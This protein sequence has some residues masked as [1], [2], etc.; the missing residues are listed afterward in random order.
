MTA[1]FLCGMFAAWAIAQALVGL[2]FVLAYARGR[3]ESEY[4]LFGLICFAL[5]LATGGIARS[6]VA[7]SP[8]AWL[9]SGI[10]TH[11]GAITATALN[12]HFVLSYATKSK[13]TRPIALVAYALAAGYVGVYLTGHWWKEG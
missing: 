3:R 13:L 2:F 1:A 11:A 6:Y 9:V 5:A 4:L 7:E 8:G 10:F 12:L